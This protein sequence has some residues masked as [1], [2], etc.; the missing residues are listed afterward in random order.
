[1]RRYLNLENTKLAL[2]MVSLLFFI[3]SIFFWYIGFFIGDSFEI[4]T[5]ITVVSILLFILLWIPDEITFR[6]FRIIDEEMSIATLMWWPIAV[7]FAL[8]I[9][10]LIKGYESHNYYLVISYGAIRFVIVAIDFINKDLGFSKAS[11][12][13]NYAIF[14]IVDILLIIGFIIVALT[15]D[16][17]YFID[18]AIIGLPMVVAWR[19]KISGR[20]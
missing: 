9:S 7:S 20:V 15:Y 6:P 10:Y 16:R 1:M 12:A 14:L 17:R 3:G 19:N 18:L 13:R 4:P 8:S 5:H 2:L 11:F